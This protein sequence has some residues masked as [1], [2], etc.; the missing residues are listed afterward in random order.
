[1]GEGWGDH[2][3]GCAE[4]VVFLHENQDCCARQVSSAT[5]EDVT[6]YLDHH[7]LSW[8]KKDADDYEAR[9]NQIFRERMLA[10]LVAS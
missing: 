10:E 7:V 3:R 1:V 5:E 9:I 8:L 4:V 2:A 6:L